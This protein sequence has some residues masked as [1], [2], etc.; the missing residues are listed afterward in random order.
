MLSWHDV[1][2]HDMHMCT[3]AVRCSAIEGILHRYHHC[4]PIVML[5][6][7]G[8]CK[9]SSLQMAFREFSAIGL[10]KPTR[11]HL[12]PRLGTSS[13][14]SLHVDVWR[15]IFLKLSLPR[16][17]VRECS[18]PCNSILYVRLFFKNGTDLTVFV[19]LQVIY[20]C[21]L[22]NGVFIN[23]LL[24]HG[25]RRLQGIYFC[26][27]AQVANAGCMYSVIVYFLHCICVCDCDSR[28]ESLTML[29]HSVMV[30]RSHLLARCYFGMMRMCTT[31]SSSYSFIFF[32][33]S[34]WLLS[35]SASCFAATVLRNWSSLISI[36]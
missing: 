5:E 27:N 8:I 15:L 24:N 11:G 33:A 28:H 1:Y 30:R 25:V 9:G 26:A 7:K 3:T 18:A 22:V 6:D 12:T 20:A 35:C 14:L 23:L 2:V 29:T 31:S 34:Y 32:S 4:G 13:L 17:G 36:Q 16:D 19:I 21:L 10:L